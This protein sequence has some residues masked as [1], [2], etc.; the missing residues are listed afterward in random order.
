[1]PRNPKAVESTLIDLFGSNLVIY[2]VYTL[3]DLILGSRKPLKPTN[4]E[5]F[6]FNI[7]RNV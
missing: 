7:A 2:K 5:H 3:R 1:M 6:R 4:C